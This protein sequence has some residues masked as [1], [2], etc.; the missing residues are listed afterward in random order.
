MVLQGEVQG[1]YPVV[2]EVEKQS[3]H[4]YHFLS[5]VAIEHTGN[6]ASGVLWNCNLYTRRKNTKF[7]GGRYHNTFKKFESDWLMSKVNIF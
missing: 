1:F 5:N 4:R 2:M 6:E 3:M 7:F